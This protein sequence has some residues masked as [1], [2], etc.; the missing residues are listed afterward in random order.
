MSK[1]QAGEM[2]KDFSL[3]GRACF[4]T[5]FS[6]INSLK[7]ETVD[8][9]P[10]FQVPLSEEAARQLLILEP[11]LGKQFKT[12]AAL[13]KAAEAYP[14]N[15]LLFAKVQTALARKF[16][17]FIVSHWLEKIVRHIEAMVKQNFKGS[18]AAKYVTNPKDLNPFLFRFLKGV[19]QVQVSHLH[20]KFKAELTR[21]LEFLLRFANANDL[22]RNSLSYR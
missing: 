21:Y 7:L 14:L 10:I 17:P 6:F 13:R 8:R 5:A 4:T 18:K 15:T 11:D 12:T 2:L 19:Y 1:A 9:T 20:A 22:F 16:K 3:L